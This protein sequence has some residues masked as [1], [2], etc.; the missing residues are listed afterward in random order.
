MMAQDW[1]ESTWE[2]IN[3]GRFIN[4]FPPDIIKSIW[5]LKRIN[6]KLCRQKL[7]IMFNQIC[8]SEEMLPIYIDIYVCMYVMPVFNDELTGYKSLLALIFIFLHG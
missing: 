7:S 6:K 3:Y 2:I 4:Q 8:I 1:A 5:Q